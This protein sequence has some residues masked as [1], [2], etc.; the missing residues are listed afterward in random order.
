MQNNVYFEWFR[1]FRFQVQFYAIFDEK[2]LEIKETCCEF[3]NDARV[4]KQNKYLIKHP[5]QTNTHSKNTALVE[6]LY[7]NGSASVYNRIDGMS[8]DL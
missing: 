5:D 8:F 2:A 1:S 7:V 6:I 4:V 3:I